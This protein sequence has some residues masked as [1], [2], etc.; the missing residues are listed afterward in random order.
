MHK[1]RSLSSTNVRYRD[2]QLKRF[3]SHV[4]SRCIEWRLGWISVTIFNIVFATFLFKAVPNP[5]PHSPRNPQNFWYIHRL[6]F[7]FQS[8]KITVMI[9]ELVWYWIAFFNKSRISW[10]ICDYCLM[11]T[12]L[13]LSRPEIR[14]K[15]LSLT[16]FSDFI[17]S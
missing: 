10:V 11:V 7:V 14:L 13:R 4:G 2:I 1:K 17:V 16:V 9:T 15:T 3:L 5:K 8:M 12:F 6:T